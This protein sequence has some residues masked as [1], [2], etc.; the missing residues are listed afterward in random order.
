VVRISSA[1]PTVLDIDT[2]WKTI[3]ASPL[4]SGG[5]LRIPIKADLG[6]E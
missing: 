5:E 3:V 1:P 2:P 6:G 4:A